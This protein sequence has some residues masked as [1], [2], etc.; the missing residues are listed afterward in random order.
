MTTNVVFC[1]A[2]GSPRVVTNIVLMVVI[3]NEAFSS[4]RQVSKSLVFDVETMVICTRPRRAIE[5]GHSV[6][7]AKEEESFS[8]KFFSGLD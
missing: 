5:V 7:E 8:R 1:A 3:G 6:S 4:K 2:V